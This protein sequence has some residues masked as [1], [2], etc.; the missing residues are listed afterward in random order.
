MG[1]IIKVGILLV[2]FVVIMYVYS[3]RRI[4]INK[5]KTKNIDSVRDFHDS[6]R[7]IMSGKN[8][9]EQGRTQQSSGDEYYRRYVT[10]YNSSEDYR[11]K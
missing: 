10:K 11:E 5:E 7:H 1:G 8:R 6:Y 4:K 3:F 2:I 9:L